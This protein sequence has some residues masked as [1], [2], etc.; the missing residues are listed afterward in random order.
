MRQRI[1][2]SG[3]ATRLATLPPVAYPVE[4]VPLQYAQIRVAAEVLGRAFDDSPV[5][6]YLMPRDRVRTVGMRAFFIS[7]LV[8][9]HK[10]G[11]AWGAIVDGMVVGAAVWSPPGSYPPGSARQARQ[12]LHLVP[13]A[14]LSPR[15]MTRSVR[16]LRAVETLHPSVEHWY[17]ATLGIDPAHQG[18]G[19]GSDLLNAVLERADAAVIPTYLETDKEQNLAYY[20]RHGFEESDTITPV[21]TGPPTWTMWREPA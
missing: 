1:P 18:R 20:R 5:M 3:H 14:P 9:A 19:Y 13:V 2:R 21:K 11:E 17:L 4:V 7:G 12:L 6:R 15:A 8:D 10:H 16:Y